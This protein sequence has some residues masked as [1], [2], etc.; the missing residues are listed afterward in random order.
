[1]QDLRSYLK[2]NILITDGAMGTYFSELIKENDVIPELA[3]LKTP[4]IIEQIHNEYID[5]G[6]KIIRTNTFAI[7][8]EFL[9]IS[10]KEQRELIKVACSIAKKCAEKKAY[11]AGNIGPIKEG[12]ST[13]ED[14]LN[15]YKDICDIFIEEKVDAIRFETFPD[16][17]F[18]DLLVS[19]V[20]EKSDVV[21][22]TDFCI[23]KN[24]FSSSGVSAKRLL[25]EVSLK[26]EIDVC[27]FN[28]GI[29]SGHMKNIVAKMAFPK[30]KYISILPNAGYPENM[31]SRIIFMDNKK[32]F[33]DNL[34]D[35]AGMGVDVVG[36]CCGSRPSYIRKL[37]DEICKEKS[38]RI[39]GDLI[40]ENSEMS[41]NISNG[42]MDL[43]SND[44]KVVAVE[45]DPPFDANYEKLVEHAHT[46]KDLGVDVLTFADSPM[47]RS[48]VDSI[49]MS[50]KIQQETDM[51]VMPHIC[52][53]D[54]NVIALRSTILG[55]YIHNIRNFLLVTGDP[56]PSVS[57]ASTTGVFDYNSIRFM[58]FV[59]QMNEEHF[60]RDPV[61]YGGALNVTLG[62]VDKIIERMQKK[63]DAGAS[64]FLTQPVFSEEAI[65]RMKY[66][67][68][69][70]DTR[71][72][73]GIM[74]LVSYKNANFIKNEFIGIDVPDEILSRYSEDMTK[75][76]GEITGAKIADEIMEKLYDYVDGFYFMLPFNRV[77]LIDKMSMLRR[78]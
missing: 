18:I 77:S 49:F 72:L 14:I 73:C 44:K 22:M 25:Q 43:F 20:R 57:R 54:K 7:G 38:P 6:A 70:I 63:I 10:K 2:E 65:E 17:Y 12:N 48:R 26:S 32:Y 64:Y 9:G 29:G 31:Q 33:C 60:S 35:I 1:M 76:E 4:H 34:R 69:H 75:E 5:A 51:L 24:G 71:I 46:L 16:F 50:L 36:G 78:S 41:G 74:P 42:L 47:G 11:V 40:L 39:N 66:I 56:V 23:D 21:I 53:R 45:L 30:D 15:E 67:K 52:C 27:G 61:F 58:K 55:A 13:E 19:Y 68:E 59:N 3:M 37:A 8:R 28:C 62:N